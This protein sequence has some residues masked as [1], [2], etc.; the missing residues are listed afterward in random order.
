MPRSRANYQT[1]ELELVKNKLPDILTREPDGISTWVR[2]NYSAEI[3]P[4]ARV[5]NLAASKLHHKWQTAVLAQVP[6][7]AWVSGP[8]DVLHIRPSSVAS[9]RYLSHELQDA[10]HE[11]QQVRTRQEL[12]EQLLEKMVPKCR[13]A[14]RPML[15]WVEYNKLGDPSV[16]RYPLSSDSAFGYNLLVLE[17]LMDNTLHDYEKNWCRENNWPKNKSVPN[18]V[19]RKYSLDA[20]QH[21]ESK[22]QEW[23]KDSASLN[24]VP[25][26]LLAIISANLSVN[27]ALLELAAIEARGMEAMGMNEQFL[28]ELNRQEVMEVPREIV[29]CGP[30]ECD[31]YLKEV[32][33][34]WFGHG[35]SMLQSGSFFQRPMNS[36][37]INMVVLWSRQLQ[38]MYILERGGRGGPETARRNHGGPGNRFIFSMV[39]AGA[40]YC[41]AST[42]YEFTGHSNPTYAVFPD[43]GK[44]ASG[45]RQTPPTH[46]ANFF[47]QAYGQV[48]FANF[49]W[50]LRFERVREYAETASIKRSCAQLLLRFAVKKRTSRELLALHQHLQRLR[51]MVAKERTE[52]KQ[53]LPM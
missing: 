48:F 8:G 34:S 52:H 35:G 31:L 32:L 42:D 24:N 11:L 44:V 47:M 30:E 3:L 6:L 18:E 13:N 14:Y 51:E 37:D 41:N 1:S 7:S 2:K 26:S 16:A 21:L 40:F 12:L 17:N 19:V 15:R 53:Y 33:T 23:C 46:A 22:V 28:R 39:M 49:D 38:Q 20:L 9:M 4:L 25:E 36:S 27:R 50:D 5:F 45:N 29:D 10:R 43:R